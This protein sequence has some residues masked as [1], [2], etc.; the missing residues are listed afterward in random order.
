[1]SDL[2]HLVNHLVIEVLDDESILL[3]T[4]G[5]ND[6]HAIGD[7]E[8]YVL[9]SSTF[10]DD[11]HSLIRCKPLPDQP[12]SM[13]ALEH[14]TGAVL[15]GHQPPFVYMPIV[16]GGLTNEGTPNYNCYNLVGG[17]YN[18]PTVA[19]TM[20]EGREGAASISLLD[21]TMLWVTGGISVG[22]T[23]TTEWLDVSKVESNNGLDNNSILS[24]GIP[25]PMPMAFH[26][27]E[28]ISDKT[29]IL[30]GGTEH[31]SK[32]NGF[33]SAWTLKVGEDFK[34]NDDSSQSWT[35]RASMNHARCQH[36]CGVI[37]IVPNEGTT[38]ITKLVVAAGG[39]VEGDNSGSN[40]VELLQI[41]EATEGSGQI[42]YSDSWELG[43][44][45]PKTVWAASS[46]TTKDQTI[47]FVAGGQYRLLDNER[48]KDIYMFRCLSANYCW[49]TKEDVTLS[50]ER[51]HS[52][53]LITPP[54]EQANEA[55]VTECN[56]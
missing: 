45:M 14:A 46:V 20:T 37:K 41:E 9:V 13:Y 28:R 1:M 30:Y 21:A 24:Q 5:F 47:L 34:S 42:T 25:L 33:D 29:V 8:A 22:V 23:D 52:V 35:P 15:R 17:G 53:S 10:A 18:I 12:Q 40:I 50:F 31:I 11:Q 7:T 56:V 32:M 16:C 4:T 6:Y 44:S 27:L 43:P 36:N 26:C 19:G 51:I 3:V 2:S 39:L 38:S 48:S 55:E 54:R 49:W